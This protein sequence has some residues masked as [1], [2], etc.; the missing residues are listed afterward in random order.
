MHNSNGT[1]PHYENIIQTVQKANES[2]D[3]Q[4]LV[5]ED[6]KKRIVNFLYLPRL[7]LP[8]TGRRKDKK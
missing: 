4:R 1:L 2:I 6:E 3:S 8:I 5:I 7:L